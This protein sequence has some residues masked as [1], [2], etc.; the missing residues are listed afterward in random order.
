ME[1]LDGAELHF[2]PETFDDLMLLARELGHN[3][4]IM[5]LVRKRDFR[6]VRETYTNY[7]KNSTGAPEAQQSKLNSS[8]FATALPTYNAASP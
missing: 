3:S 1:I 6:G 8:P 4:L 7:Y 2:S 5:C